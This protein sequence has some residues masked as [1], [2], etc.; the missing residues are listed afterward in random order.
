M[1]LQHSTQAAASGVAPSG[2]GRNLGVALLVIAT[3][4]A[5]IP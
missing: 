3:A 1:S 5:P 2:A 4:L